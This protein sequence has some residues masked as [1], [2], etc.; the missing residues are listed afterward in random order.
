LIRYNLPFPPSVNNLFANGKKGRYR[1][2]RYEAWR[3]L[4]GQEILVQGR[5]SLKGKVS[6]SVCAVRPDRR[7]RD[8]SNLLKPVED[9]LVDMG[10][11][12]DDSLVE[13]ITIQW[14]EAGSFE[15][16][17]LVQPHEGGV[18]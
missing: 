18:A 2:D 16:V 9:L 13:R 7:R 15:C 12:E 8:V 4:A 6:L 3:T 17:V 11:I 14:A 1:T 10:V 5:K